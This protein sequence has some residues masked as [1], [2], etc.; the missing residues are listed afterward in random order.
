VVICILA[1]RA[2]A[3]GS[4][5]GVPEL[6]R[7]RVTALKDIALANVP[8]APAFPFDAPAA[9]RAQEE[10]AR[11]LGLPREWRNDLGMIFVLVPAGTFT[12]GSPDSEPGRNSDERQHEVRL[13]RPFYLGRCETTVAAFRRFVDETK[14][15]TDIEK[16]GG[17]HAH[18][19]KA[20]WKHRPGTHW[21]NPGYAAPFT[22]EGDHPVV[23]VS[24]TDSVAFCSW[25]ERR[26]GM[27]GLVFGLPSEAQWEWTAPAR[28]PTLATGACAQCI[29]AGRAR[30][31]R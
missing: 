22:L 10:C 23:H 14:Y 16:N 27:G 20:D 5:T 7:E 17:G 9:R 18:D 29:P 1:A 15:V 6:A 12:M 21:R 19:D 4:A 26:T 11:A 28:S 13:S 24:H 2:D 30:S 31:C 8:E 25:L 3:K